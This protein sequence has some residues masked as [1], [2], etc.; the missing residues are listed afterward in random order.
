[1]QMQATKKAA[2]KGAAD[3]NTY[4]KD[5]TMPAAVEQGIV[6]FKHGVRELRQIVN[7]VGIQC[8]LGGEVEVQVA[9][10]QDLEHLPGE[11]VV[12]R[13]F[14]SKYPYKAAKNVKGIEFSVLAE[15]DPN[16]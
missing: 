4:Q 10:V 3:E 1:M 6:D 14:S 16:A 13:R 11:L 5:N 8:Y 12:T 2:H 9:S 15:E 7:V